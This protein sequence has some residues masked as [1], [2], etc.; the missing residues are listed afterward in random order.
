MAE[1][2]A[3]QDI[4]ALNG[5][6]KD[7]E[8]QMFQ[9]QIEFVL[10]AAKINIDIIDSNFNVRY[11]DPYWKSRYGEPRNKKCYEYFMGRSDV[12][13][14]CGIVEALKTK[15]KIVAEEI[16][17]KEGN[18][19]IE[20]T[21]IPFQ[22]EKGEWLVAEVN[23]DISER[24]AAEQEI[25]H[26]ASF[27]KLNPSP[28]IEIDASGNFTFCNYATFKTLE[29]LGLKKDAK[30]F[31]PQDIDKIME[32][33]KSKKL[34]ETLYREVKVKG[35]VFGENIYLTPKFNG[36]R[37]YAVDI[38][39][40]KQ[41]E[42]TLRQ[43]E[44]RYRTLAESAHDFIFIIDKDGRIRYV[45][46]ATAKSVNYKPN[47]IIGK[48][49]NDIF[50]KSEFKRQA[51]SLKKAFNNGM[52]V[53]AEDIMR[54]SNQKIWLSTW[55]APLKNEY[56]EVSAVMGVSR[57]ITRHKLME[58]ALKEAHDELEYR[59]EE[60]TAKLR[61]ANERLLS[62]MAKRKK[63]EKKLIESEKEYRYLVEHANSIILRMNTS[64]KITFFNEFAQK[65]F[66]YSK[67][68][69]MGKNI[70][71]KIVPV[72]DHAGNDIDVMMKNIKK[73]PDAF[74]T[75]ETE[76]VC[77][78]GTRAWISWTNKG[79]YDKK[80]RLKELICIGNDITER[81]KAEDALR[82][83]NELLERIFAT[84]YFLIAYLDTKFNFIR[85]NN[86]YAMQENQKPE[87][88]IGKNHFGLYPGRENE[89][90]FK[91][92][93]ESGK[94]YTAYAKAFKYTTHPERG[95]TYWDWNLHPVK[96][97][98]GKVEGLLLCLVNVTETKLNEE[99]LLKTQKELADAKR[100]SDIGKLA[101]T[102]AH[103]LR[104]PLAAIRTAA[105]N[106]KK[107]SQ[108]PSLDSHI[109]NIEKKVLESDQIINNL[110]FYSHIKM[111]QFEK[112]DICDALN[113][114]VVNAR[115]RFP[116]YKVEIRKMYKRSKK[117]IIEA[118][119]VQA[120]ELFNN[121]LSNAYESL[122]G[123]KGTIEINVGNEEDEC[124][125]ISFKDSGCGINPEDLT[126]ISEPFFTTKPKGTGL[127]LV[128]CYQIAGLHNGK[129]DIASK[130]GKGTT[131]T[132]T[133]PV[134]QQL[135]R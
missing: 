102:I 93:V 117:N 24:K 128:V 123:K 56:G 85:V 61:V 103:E 72:G 80:G 4:K 16:L 133:L 53:Y 100:L 104:N 19:P 68:E 83:T 116:E 41:I 119:P 122:P 10:A 57:D 115:G 76:N 108:N 46:K 32:R 7:T 97:M 113:D 86:A 3:R 118:D 42:E 69:I 111:P 77:R 112:T 101:A 98:S 64:G 55:L 28:V 60:R 39:G 18:R 106:I 65:F 89:V 96:D 129:I 110:L 51:Q 6:K 125:I 126:K 35:K 27:P 62:E 45:N 135:G 31:L 67:A 43:S 92:V 11:I 91:R 14:A 127:G 84:T 120:R 29:K 109:V 12:C 47:E 22:D 34:N 17:V 131:V 25:E 121:I 2:S 54:I 74:L 20:V 36:I 66:G 59:V 15:K 49:I 81:K 124:L 40:Y 37:I 99:R 105:Y 87:Y 94:A 38:S 95:I 70:S 5:E 63:T 58:A 52:P 9:K 26:L 79:V 1:D 82:Y 78:D 30:I 90:I 107:K 130:A 114:C 44:L 21:T 132:V 8:L 13:P 88:F 33:L 75:N 71:G 73:R 48:H 134:S 50:P 23:V